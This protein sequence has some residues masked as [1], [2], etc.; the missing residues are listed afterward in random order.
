[1]TKVY[2]GIVTREKDSDYGVV[3]PDFPG[4]VTAGSTLKEANSMAKEALQFHIDGMLEDGEDLPEPTDS[5]DTKL[6][7]LSNLVTLLSV[8]VELS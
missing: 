4:C 1:M 5:V 6:A 7:H 2:V 8:K 3:F